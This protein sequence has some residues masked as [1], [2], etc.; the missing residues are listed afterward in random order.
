VPRPPRSARDTR[1][2]PRHGDAPW[3]ATSTRFEHAAAEHEELLEEIDN[4]IER[5][6]LLPGNDEEIARYLDAIEVRSPREWEM[7]REISR[8]GPLARPEAFPQAHGAATRRRTR[9]AGSSF[10]RSA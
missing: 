7:L 6:K 10:S 3:P 1:G 8:R 5:L 4:P 2:A 9:R